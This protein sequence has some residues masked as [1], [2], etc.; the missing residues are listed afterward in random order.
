MDLFLLLMAALLAAPQGRSAAQ[1]AA[2][3][4]P[5]RVEP[6]AVT[7]GAVT[8]EGTLTVPAGAQMP[9]AFVPGLLDDEA[10]WILGSRR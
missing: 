1:A 9:P 2:P 6:F 7:N 10:R 5:Y 4:R 8:L 3:R